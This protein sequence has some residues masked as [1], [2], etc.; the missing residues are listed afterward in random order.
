MSTVALSGDCSGIAEKRMGT[1]ELA[2]GDKCKG[3]ECLGGREQVGN[4]PG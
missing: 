2:R 3:S 1:G 4:G